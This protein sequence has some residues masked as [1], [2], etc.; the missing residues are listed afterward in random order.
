MAAASASSK[1]KSTKVESPKNGQILVWLDDSAGQN[2]EIK[3]VLLAIFERV[4]CFNSPA[5]CFELV[6]SAEPDTPCISILVSGRYGEAFVPTRFQPLG[7]VKDIYVFCM[8]TAK[9]G[10]WA[11]KCDKV[12]IVES[13]FAKILKA[14]QS[15]SAT[16]AKPG[17]PKSVRFEGKQDDEQDKDD[18]PMTPQEPVLAPSREEL[19][20]KPLA[21]FQP[22]S[23]MFDQLAHH[24]LLQNA[25]DEDDGVD[26]F[27]E[28][29]NAKKLQGAHVN[30][31]APLQR[32]CREGPFIE[33]VNASDLSQ[34]WAIRW[35][36][37]ILYRRLED[38][39]QRFIRDRTKLTVNYG[40]WVN[41]TELETLKQH[42]GEV[43]VFN[44]PFVAHASRRI[45]LESQDKKPDEHTKHRVVFEINIDTRNERTVLFAEVAK[46]QVLFWFGARCRLV[47]IEWVDEQNPYWVLGLT[48]QPTQSSDPSVDALYNYYLKNLT[49]L[50]D[51]YR[52]IGRLL[53]QRG[54]YYRAEM[55][56]EGKPH[57]EEL[58]EIAVR[59]NQHA[60]ALQY[61][62]QAPGDSDDAQLWRAYA[63]LLTSNENIAKG[64]TLLKEIISNANDKIVRAR[65]N[66]GLGFASL[67]TT[68]QAD[69]A[70]E[71]F[72]LGH[73]TLSKTLP[74][75]HPELATSLIGIGYAQFVKQEFEDSEKHFQ[76]ARRIQKQV[77]PFQHPDCAKARS[78]LAHCLLVRPQTAKQGLQELA[79]A[80]SIFLRTFRLDYKTHPQVVLTNY[81]IDRAQRGKPLR[82]RATLL[83]YI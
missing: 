23:S 31:K 9:H 11:R 83:D 26:Q 15:G 73:Q 21:R 24:L 56:F 20:P 60:K 12:R 36:L 28:Y 19:L 10:Q 16:V 22:D 48:L 72:S 52:A 43:M 44:E 32:L 7:Q 37:R 33:H 29:C 45:A 47:K 59:R 17:G 55:W 64:R 80:M 74:P 8:D 63:Y 67:V 39:H 25:A 35:F 27:H 62:Q 82:A 65:A 34:L 1:A 42:I 46:E 14:M 75:L 54:S 13:D 57:V 61:L 53:I 51:T 30:P 6:E 68:Q 5:G 69:Q 4:H 78:G 49:N 76:T 79:T 71:Y 38:E 41:T 2:P 18:E 81:D 70:L 58:A 66:I 50:N 3:T 77:L 40:T